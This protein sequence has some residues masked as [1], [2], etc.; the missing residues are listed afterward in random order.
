MSTSSPGRVR[1]PWALVCLLAVAMTINFFDRGNLAV[2]APV[3]APDLGLSSLSLGFLFSAF[4][5]TYALGQIPSGWL[6]D[7]ID[8]RWVYAG[9]FLI[10]S[11]ATFFTGV[12]VSFA[13]LLCLRLLLGVGESMAYP[14][15]S[16]IL[17]ITFPENRRGLANSLIDLG[18][19]VGPAVG[20]LCG[21]LL[22]AGMGWRFLFLLTGGAGLLWLI[23]W[24]FLA[25]AKSG[26]ANLPAAHQTGWGEL[27]R[28][29]AVWGTCGGLCGANYAWYFLLS[30]LP[31]YLVSE[32]HFSLNSMAIWAAAPYLLMVVSSVGGGVLA[33]RLISR[34]GSAVRV[35]RGFLTTGLLLTSVLLP[36]VLIS[37]IEWALAGLL[38]ACFAF[39]IYASNLWSLSQTLAGTEAAGRWTGIQNACGNLAG[40]VAPALTGWIVARTGQFAIAFVAAS[41]ACLLGSASFG[42]LVR[43]SD[44][45]DFAT[46]G[47]SAGMTASL[48][49]EANPN[50]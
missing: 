19:R 11:L 41:V 38:L 42:F 28:K 35:R 43:A 36:T 25:P 40:V 39:G 7:R 44:A 6:V 27:L 37:R 49:A 21:G 29:R 2:A 24:M 10:W 31:S 23:P 16:R 32:R 18:A 33:D 8:V 26:P 46:N 1:H 34:G 48:R 3:L 20:T 17:V 47:N 5:W 30:W 4:F 45:A 22:V 9:G 15:C 50:G 13:T 14:A 12:V